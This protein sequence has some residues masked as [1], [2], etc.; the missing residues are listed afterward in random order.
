MQTTKHM[1]ARMSQ[2]GIKK[3]MVELALEVGRIDGDRHILDQRECRAAIERLKHQQK[4]FEH[5]LRKGGITVV[6]DG[7][8]C[9]TT[10]R[11]EA[12]SQARARENQ[13]LTMEEC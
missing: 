9:I 6:T 10:F 2:R 4:L 5:A 7:D 11:T 8:T 12:Y 13:N 3:E 1:T